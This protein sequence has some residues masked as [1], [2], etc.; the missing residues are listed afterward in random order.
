MET[1]SLWA[2]LL[3]LLLALCSALAFVLIYLRSPWHRSA[4]T[5]SASKMAIARPHAAGGA[6]PAGGANSAAHS[7]AQS[8]QPIP[9]AHLP[10]AHLSHQAD[11]SSAGGALAHALAGTA[12]ITLG[13][14]HQHL[15]AT[16]AQ[17]N[18]AAALQAQQNNA[19]AVELALRGRKA[20]KRGGR[21]HV[22]VAATASAPSPSSNSVG[23]GGER[24]TSRATSSHAPYVYPLDFLQ[25]APPVIVCLTTLPSRVHHIDKCLNSI[26]TQNYPIAQMMLAVPEESRRE[27]TRYS[28]PDRVRKDAILNVVRVAQDFGPSTALITAWQAIPPGAQ[29]RETLIITLDDD[30][31]Y[32][33]DTV[34]TLVR[35]ALAHPDSAVGFAGY[36][37]R[38]RPFVQPNL[39]YAPMRSERPEIAYRQAQRNL[40]QQIVYAAA[41]QQANSGGHSQ[42]LQQAAAA[43]LSASN[44]SSHHA[45]GGVSSPDVSLLPPYDPLPDCPP[46]SSDPYSSP[47]PNPNDAYETQEVDVIT[48]WR[49]GM[50]VRKRFL[51]E[52]LF[53][54]YTSDSA[55]AGDSAYWSSDEWV[56]SHLAHNGAGRR[57]ILAPF[58]PVLQRLRLRHGRNSA[59]ASH[60]A[61]QQTVL[62]YA[63]REGRFAP[64]EDDAAEEEDHSTMNAIPPRS[65]P[66][67]SARL[68]QLMRPFRP[69]SD[70]I[71]AVTIEKDDLAPKSEPAAAAG[72]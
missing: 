48:A 51:D 5:I 60:I 18:A 39:A 32:H 10:H 40:Q 62:E 33:P 16:S 34:A 59:S 55:P 46:D 37:L 9:H 24:R 15:A 43:A 12:N 1:P 29:H 70:G 23:L 3:T 13:A 66:E 52:A 72:V 25:S 69:E 67:R 6:N 11:P 31:V 8:S 30:Q 54:D 27:H 44:S 7:S 35:H 68:H 26:K 57:V 22:T 58:E 63:V 19:A 28:L 17:T 45:L 56:S 21:V 4:L 36:S 61:H 2:L 64:G 65:D 38:G 50:C 71:A 49:G 41:G 53:Q 42:A 14:T 47:L 20:K